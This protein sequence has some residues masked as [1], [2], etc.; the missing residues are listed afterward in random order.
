MDT[1]VIRVCIQKGAKMYQ[2]DQD[3]LFGPGKPD[4]YSGYITDD[5]ETEI[6]SFP[7]LKAPEKIKSISLD[8]IS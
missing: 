8:K 6:L 7:V 4:S 1:E 2:F 5:S 3:I